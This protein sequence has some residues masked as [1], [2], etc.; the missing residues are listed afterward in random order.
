MATRQKKRTPRS[1]STARAATPKRV[2]AAAAQAAPL[3]RSFKVQLL[4][5]GGFGGWGRPGAGGW[6]RRGR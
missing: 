1:T 2:T 6:G 5:L 4:F 3:G